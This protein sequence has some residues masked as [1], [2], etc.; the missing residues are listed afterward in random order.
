MILKPKKTTFNTPAAIYKRVT[1]IFR[2]LDSLVVYKAQ[3]TYYQLWHWYSFDKDTL[4]FTWVADVTYNG[5]AQ[6]TITVSDGDVFMSGGFYFYWDKTMNGGKGGWIKSAQLP[7]NYTT[8]LDA[9]YNNIARYQTN[10]YI[11]AG[12]IDYIITG[13]VSGTK[14]QPIKGVIMPLTSMNIKY[15]SDDVVID[16]EDLVVID[17]NLYSAESPDYSI[18]HMPRPYKTHYVTLNSIL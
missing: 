1:R 2:S 8:L 4:E 13:E 14:T 5:P 16:E 10:Q 9:G 18:K 6:S 12:T 15:H 3:G 7:Q 11:Y 17:G